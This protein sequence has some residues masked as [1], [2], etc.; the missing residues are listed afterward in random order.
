MKTEGDLQ[1]WSRRAGGIC[2][3]G[4]G[5]AVVAVSIWTPLVDPGIAQRW[6]SW[7]NILWLSPVPVVTGGIALTRMGKLIEP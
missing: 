2:L 3:V 4:V 1:A 5:I 7:P 6:F